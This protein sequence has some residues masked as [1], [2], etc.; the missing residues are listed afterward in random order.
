M[1]PVQVPT[2]GSGVGAGVGETVVTAD[3]DV[4]NA[5]PAGN[6]A[7]VAADC[8]GAGVTDVRPPAG[9]RVVVTSPDDTGGYADP[10]SMPTPI[11][12][13][14]TTRSPRILTADVTRDYTLFMAMAMSISSKSITPNF[15]GLTI[16]VS[17]SPDREKSRDL[18]AEKPR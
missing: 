2:I 7:G 11:P 15:F 1:D 16:M 18:D 10:I 3:A 6:G 9:V 13:R 8:V 12:A 17:V 14:N 5:V 4:G